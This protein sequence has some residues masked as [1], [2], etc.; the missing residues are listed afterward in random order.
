MVVCFATEAEC[1]PH[2]KA[3][4]QELL[5]IEREEALDADQA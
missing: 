2:M 5:R 4:D 1:L 3:L